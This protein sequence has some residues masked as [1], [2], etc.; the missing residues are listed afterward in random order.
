M[1]N[2]G[3]KR[4]LGQAIH[5]FKSLKNM[6]ERERTSQTCLSGPQAGQPGVTPERAQGVQSQGQAEPLGTSPAGSSRSHRWGPSPLPED[7]GQCPCLTRSAVVKPSI[8]ATL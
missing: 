2:K 7:G 3:L 8:E 6:S 1:W 4:L 5:F